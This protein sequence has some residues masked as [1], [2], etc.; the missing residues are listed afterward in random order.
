[1]SPGWERLP[2]NFVETKCMREKGNIRQ[3]YRAHHQNGYE[4]GQIRRIWNWQVFLQMRIHRRIMMV[5][6]RKKS[7]MMEYTSATH[8]KISIINYFAEFTSIDVEAKILNDL[9]IKEILQGTCVS[10]EKTLQI[11][12]C[13]LNRFVW[14][15][16]GKAERED[17]ISFNL[18]RSDSLSI[19][20]GIDFS[21]P[22]RKSL[23]SSS[24]LSCHYNP[25]IKT[26]SIHNTN[27]R[28]INKNLSRLNI[29]FAPFS[30]L[31]FQQDLSFA[32]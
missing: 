32:E 7:I 30:A 20:T 26:R 28:R 17:K 23:I 25:M 1:M 8:L 15:C 22:S 19:W 14:I 18:L 10:F 31:S 11:S 29:W 6:F 24:A 3:N 16:C 4:V 12:C 27:A 2:K 5:I 13:S 9:E 21:L